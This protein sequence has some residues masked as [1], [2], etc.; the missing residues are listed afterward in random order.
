VHGVRIKGGKATYT[1]RYVRTKMLAAE[2]ETGEPVG[3]K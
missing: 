2:E 1:N 3:L